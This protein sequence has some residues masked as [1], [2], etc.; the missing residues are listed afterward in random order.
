MKFEN[1]DYRIEIPEIKKVLQDIGVLLKAQMPKGWGF[2]LMIFSFGKGGSTFYI[3]NAQRE[4]VIKMIEED[5][6][7]I[8]KGQK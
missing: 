8:L 3:S 2:N 1:E 7:P 4:D 6:L 5:Y